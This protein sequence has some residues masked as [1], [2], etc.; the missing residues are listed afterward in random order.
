MKSLTIATRNSPLAL[1][2]AEFIKKKLEHYWPSLI[3]I[4]LPMTTTGDKF[5]QQPLQAIGGKGLFV[6]EL[7]EALLDGRADIAVHSMKDV[8]AE[9]P[10]ELDIM[11]ITKRHSPY[12]CLVSTK[13]LTLETLPNAQNIGTSSLRRSAQLKHY[14]NDV[15][16]SSLRGNLHTRLKKLSDGEFDAIILAEAGL[17][18]LNIEG[19]HR[20][21]FPKDIMLPACGQG[22]L[23]IETRK[24]SSVIPL[25]L[26]LHDENTAC[27]LMAERAVNRL[28]GGNCH[29]P[30]AVLGELNASDITIEARV[31]NADGSIVLSANT[32]GHKDNALL[33]AKECAELL[34]AQGAL[35]IMEQC[36]SG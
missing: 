10:E 27:C 9:L 16:I 33:L 19:Y 13:P 20:I 11:T 1:W 25:L 36:R 6:K 8:P 21:I 24:N 4:L 26:P 34:I 2:Q 31:L 14:R 17:E 32:K 15:M 35:K 23:G 3:V 30:L 29:A 5:L 28:L 12:D 18:R 7:E 22:A